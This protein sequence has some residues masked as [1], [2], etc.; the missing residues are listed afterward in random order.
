VI[1]LVSY[2]IAAIKPK[3]IAQGIN[4]A[5]AE[6]YDKAWSERRFFVSGSD[7]S[8]RLQFLRFGLN[9]SAKKLIPPAENLDTN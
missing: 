5:K 8:S 6:A 1:G 7:L 9:F 3:K 2:T 4:M